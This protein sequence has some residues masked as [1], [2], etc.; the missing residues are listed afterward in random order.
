VSSV[1]FSGCI[2]LTCV[3]QT[4]PTKRAASPPSTPQTKYGTLALPAPSVSAPSRPPSVLTLLRCPLTRALTLSGFALS[5]VG[6]SFD[7]L[8]VLFCFSPVARGG[9]AFSVRTPPPL[10]LAKHGG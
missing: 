8:F 9:L 1:L 5:A 6:T 7:V 10:L 2:W 4:L 3:E